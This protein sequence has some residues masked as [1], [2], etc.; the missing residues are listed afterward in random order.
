MYVI[1]LNPMKDNQTNV[2]SMLNYEEENVMAA[3]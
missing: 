1:I 3:K 2:Y